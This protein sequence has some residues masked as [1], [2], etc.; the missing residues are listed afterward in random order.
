VTPNSTPQP[1]QNEGA[2]LGDYWLAFAKRKWLILMI[3]TA[4]VFI[5]TV[6]TIRQPKIYEAVT[7]VEIDLQV[8]RVLNDVNDVY[9]LGDM[10]YWDSKSYFETQYKIIQSYAVAAAVVEQLHL[11]R[12]LSFLG[13]D[14]VED[15]EELARALKIIDPVEV[16]RTNMS[17]DPV[18]ES[19]LVRIRYRGTD[20]QH[21]TA[22]ANA[23]AKAFIEQNLERKL[24]STRNALDWLSEQTGD[25]KTKLESAERDLYAFMEANDILSISM[26]QRI[27]VVGTHLAE[28]SR[29]ASQTE[30]NL[31]KVRAN[32][33]SLKAAMDKSD[34]LENVASLEVLRDPLIRDLKMTMEKLQHEYAELLIR[35][36][37]KHPDV[38]RVKGQLDRARENLRREV[39]NFTDA[40]RSEYESTLS[41]SQALEVELEKVKQQARDLTLKEVEFNRLQRERD[42][43]QRLFE[44]VLQ[45]LREVDLSGMLKINNIR[46]LDEAKVPNEP[47]RPRVRVNIVVGFTLGFLL[48]FGVA[49]ILEMLD[50]TLKTQEDIKRYLGIPLLGIIPQVKL[51]PN[52]PKTSRPNAAD[53]YSFLYPKSSIAECCRQ[54]RTN[55]NFM[56]LGKPLRRILVTSSSPREGKTTIAANLGITM[57]L[58]GKRVLVLDTD[59]RRPRI[60]K[61]FGMDNDS[62][63]S[64]IIMGTMTEEQAVQH[65]EIENLDVLTCGPI[66]P[67]PAELIGSDAFEKI[68]NTLSGMYDWI[69]FDSP[70]VIAVTDALV[71]SRLVDGVVIVVKFGKT[72]RDVASQARA[73]LAGVNAP[74]LGAVI[75]DLDMDNKEYGH[76]YYYY[77]HH[78]GYYY[79]EHE[80]EGDDLT[81]V[82]RSSA[83]QKRKRKI[84]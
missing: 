17:V 83:S 53:V 32:Y 4:V 8:D 70:P 45:R 1:N 29:E 34:G 44:Q 59:M 80:K 55:I 74:V 10:S 62:G 61:A 40:V 84:K 79:G 20:A 3:I 56:S 60:H 13:L 16:L 33:Q 50:K 81:G 78:Y 26:D 77:Y 18:E 39:R 41:A 28:L 6:F 48:A 38:L 51:D 76:Y 66:P 24:I 15:E 21:I 75:N 27:N 30:S 7:T 14:K 19:R 72:I 46:L 47:I 57:A 12:D 9:Q 52:D 69:I 65:S 35:Y 11:D 64:N 68:V 73:Q 67:N 42:V 5:T 23:V 63:L 54:V 82:N 36:K 37:D 25:L 2:S 49:L 31:I 43:N 71:L 22:I 58:S